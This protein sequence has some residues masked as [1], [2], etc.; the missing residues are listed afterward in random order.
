MMADDDNDKTVFG[1]PLPGA[2]RP[3]SGRGGQPP[4]GRPAQGSGEKTVFGQPLPPAGSGPGRVAPASAPQNPNP[5]HS[6]GGDDTWLGG[7]PTRSP[8]IRPKP[9]RPLRKAAMAASRRSSPPI[10]GAMAMGSNRRRPSK[11]GGNNHNPPRDRAISPRR[12]S[13]PPDRTFFPKSSGPKISV[14]HS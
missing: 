11:V 4:A 10:P 9:L 6:P 13:A 7:A 12:V 2:P 5:W 8:A 3:E 1:Q 14:S